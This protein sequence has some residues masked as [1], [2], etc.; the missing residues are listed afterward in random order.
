MGSAIGVPIEG[1]SDEI[2]NA[3]EMGERWDAK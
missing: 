3:L 2:I 1:R